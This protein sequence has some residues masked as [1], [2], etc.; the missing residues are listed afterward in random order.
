LGRFERCH[1]ISGELEALA[2]QIT[3]LP[4]AMKV[5]IP[6]IG[7]IIWAFFLWLAGVWRLGP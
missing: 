4:Q 5:F 6:L 2:F 3:S 7:F 1:F